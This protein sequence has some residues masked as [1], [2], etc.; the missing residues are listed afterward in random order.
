MHGL[1]KPSER[2]AGSPSDCRKTPELSDVGLRLAEALDSVARIPL[3][4]LLEDIDA[5]ETLQN[6]ALPDDAARALEALVLGH[7]K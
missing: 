3:A 4:A 5:L 1:L 2:T 6:V 7:G